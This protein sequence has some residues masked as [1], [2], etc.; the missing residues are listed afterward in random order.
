MTDIGRIVQDAATECLAGSDGL[1]PLIRKLDEH[2]SHAAW[3]LSSF[4]E[5]SLEME[6]GRDP[7]T[8]LLNR[9]F[10]PSLMQKFIRISIKNKIPF[11]V[12]MF[13][14]D[15]FKDIND[16]HGHDAGDSILSQVGELLL[17]RI[18]SGDFIFRYGGE[19]FLMILSGS[20]K[21]GALKVADKIR[22]NIESHS[23]VINKKQPLNVTVSAGVAFH[24]GHPDY[25]RL[26]A[27][28]DK[29]LY[30]AKNGGRNRAILA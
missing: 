4:V 19:E 14:I 11:A 25:S 9:R 15:Y 23:F 16:A 24:E 12:L 22:K 6:S 17:Q 26:I 1:N 27:T 20:T 7:L 21:E 13:D 8:K 2:V 30:K 29:A 18:R 3:L 5:H 28:A 10:I